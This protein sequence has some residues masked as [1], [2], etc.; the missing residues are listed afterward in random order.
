MR[1]LMICLFAAVCFSGCSSSSEEPK[2]IHFGPGPEGQASEQPVGKK[3][4]R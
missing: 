3:S 1:Q 4:G 2:E